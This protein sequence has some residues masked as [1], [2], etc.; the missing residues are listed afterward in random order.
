[1]GGHRTYSAASVSFRL[2]SVLRDMEQLQRSAAV[3]IFR[4]CVG[5]EAQVSLHMLETGRLFL[6]KPGQPNHDNQQTQ[7]E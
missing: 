1:M 6:D 7:S 3:V 5:P 4:Q 2:V